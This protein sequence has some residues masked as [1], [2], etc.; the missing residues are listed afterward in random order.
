MDKRG[1]NYSDRPTS[2]LHYEMYI[3]LF[4]TFNI[5]YSCDPAL[6]RMNWKVT[7]LLPYG[8]QLRRQRRFMHDYLNLRSITSL[9]PLQ[10][11]HIRL[12][13]KSILDDPDHFD[14][15]IFRCISPVIRLFP[16]L[17]VSYRMSAAIIVKMTY[18]R[19]VALENDELVR[20]LLIPLER[21]GKA[22]APGLS[23]VD[24]L[25]ICKL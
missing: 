17:T 7:F 10:T 24:I 15:H 12:L 3:S 22:G 18:G 4:F 11:E 6:H 13:L 2:I 14:K 1:A 9:Q 25:P 16:V 21:G 5:L 23:E 8:D 19:E 20:K